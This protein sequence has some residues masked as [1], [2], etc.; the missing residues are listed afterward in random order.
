MKNKE[1]INHSI[2][3]GIFFFLAG[4]ALLGYAVTSYE[5]AFN[6]NWSQSPYLFPMMVAAVF[7]FLAACLIK[8]GTAQWKTGAGDG[9]GKKQRGE[10]GRRETA[11]GEAERREAASGEAECREAVSG[12]TGSGK[13]VREAGN[14]KGIGIVL[15]LCI[16]YYGA[17]FYVKMPYINV[18][19]FT[20]FFTFS[21]FEVATW[22]FLIVMMAYMGVR[23]P[24]ILAAVPLGF[25][26][27]LSIAFR[28]MLNVLLP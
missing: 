7:L 26:L 20:F 14:W 25:T 23:K 8:E 9:S 5:K 28:T 27:F 24:L 21:T 13:P 6:K 4:A 2:Q 12:E 11:G 1:K 22:L 17:L 15:L 19:I 16:V 3:E 10:A 18:G